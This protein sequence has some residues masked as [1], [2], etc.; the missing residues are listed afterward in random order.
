MSVVCFQVEVYATG[1]SLVQR[2]PTECRVYMSVITVP[3]QR[4]GLGPL[5]RAVKSWGKK[6]Y[7]IIQV[8]NVQ[9]MNGIRFKRVTRN[10]K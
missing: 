4:G 1:R 7:Y 2:R 9:S 10:A 3:R 8:V 5:T 6:L